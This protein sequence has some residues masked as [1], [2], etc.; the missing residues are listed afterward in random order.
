M[1]YL[2]DNSCIGYV[3]W[4]YSDPCLHGGRGYDLPT[5]ERSSKMNASTLLSPGSG[6]ARKKSLVVIVPCVTGLFII[7]NY[8]NPYETASIMKSKVKVTRVLFVAQGFLLS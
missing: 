8:G 4:K 7:S 5:C 2:L 6:P 1:W 3:G